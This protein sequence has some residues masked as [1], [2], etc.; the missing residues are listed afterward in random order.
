MPVVPFIPAIIGAV[1]SIGAS[2]V[3]S[4]MQ[5]RSPEEQAA[6]GGASGAGSALTGAGSALL[7]GGQATLQQ[8]INYFQTLLRGNR[9]AQN[10][11]VAGP[12][13]A[14]EDTYAGAAK[15]LETGN[16][17][18]AARD[19]A[20]ADLARQKAGQISSLITG[21]QPAAASAL[22]TIGMGQ[23]NAGTGA[24]S[25]GG[26]IFSN[27]LG[28]GFQNRVYQQGQANQFG[29]N[30]GSLLYGIL[31]NTKWGKSAPSTYPS[32]DTVGPP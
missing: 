23:I 9:A 4:K 26:G 12:R 30:I 10:L 8:P 25:A 3:A 19:Q 11:A 13:G 22:S 14:I 6:L 15:N 5:S 2:A 21:V 24:A 28:S 31:S 1:G 18:G 7:S 27:L 16:V 17:R 32:G 29:S 20:T